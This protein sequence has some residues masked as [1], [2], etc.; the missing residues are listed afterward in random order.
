MAQ[1]SA[2]SGAVKDLGKPDDGEPHVR[3]DEGRLETGLVLGPQRLQ[4]DAGTAPDQ[5]ATAPVSY[6]TPSKYQVLPRM[7]T[8]KTR[9]KKAGATFRIRARRL[10]Q[11][12]Y[13][14]SATDRAPDLLTRARSSATLMSS[15]LHG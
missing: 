1:G 2:D 12:T 11:S 6:S 8:P 5:R 10:R 7:D 13:Y 3:I 4:L 15:T 9:D 14:K